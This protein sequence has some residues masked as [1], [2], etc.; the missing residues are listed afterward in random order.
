METIVMSALEGSRPRPARPKELQPRQEVVTR[1]R[2]KAAMKGSKITA[3]DDPEGAALGSDLHSGVEVSMRESKDGWI[4]RVKLV[5]PYRANKAL[6]AASGNPN[7]RFMHCLPP[8]HDTDTVV[9]ADIMAET[10]MVGG[11][12][13]TNAVL[14]SSAAMVFDQAENRLRTIEVVLVATL[15][16]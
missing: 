11:F 13:V 9:G 8:F 4:D 15:G 12:E 7:A 3:I 1:A 16:S 14:E 2:E 6:L 5:G 10:G